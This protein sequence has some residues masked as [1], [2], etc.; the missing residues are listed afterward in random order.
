MEAPLDGVDDGHY[1]WEC[2]LNPTSLKRQK[3]VF[4]AIPQSFKIVTSAAFPQ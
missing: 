4:I 3:N 2:I 1:K